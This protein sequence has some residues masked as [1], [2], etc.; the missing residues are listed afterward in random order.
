MGYNT[1]TTTGSITDEFHK[2]NGEKEKEK[3]QMPK[4]QRVWFRSYRT[5]K[6]EKN[7]QN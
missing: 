7:R 4:L 3:D 5:Q 2:H 6:K 1:T